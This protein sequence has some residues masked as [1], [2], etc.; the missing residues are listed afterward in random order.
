MSGCPSPFRV[1]LPLVLL[2]T[3]LLPACRVDLP[4]A[5]G[6]APAPT[7]SG[8]GGAPTPAARPMPGVEPGDYATDP[9][10]PGFV[11][12]WPERVE[13]AFERFEVVTGLDF[14]SSTR[15]RI[16]LRPFGDEG[17]T[18]ELRGEIIQ[19][20]RRTVLHVNVEPLLG[21]VQDADRVLLRALG[22]AA[23]QDAERRH[24]PV[25]AWV[26][27]LA[28]TAAAGDL[29]ARLD[30]LLRRRMRGEEDVLRVDA[31]DEG[32]AE[33]T[34]LAALALLAERG[35]PGAVRR[36]LVFMADGD[37]A[38]DVLGRLVREPDGVWDRPARLALRTRI[39]Q[40]DL[41]PWRLLER[42]RDAARETGRAGFES[43]VP[44][45]VP[46]EIADE[47]HVLRA[48]LAAA[49]GDFATAR[50]ELAALSP[51]A[52]GRL[53]DPAGVL[54]L[55]VRIESRAG[56]DAGLVRRL[57]LQL[58][59]DH[60]RS[61]A[62]QA[63]REANP[64]LGIQEDPQRWLAA[65]RARIER[66]GTLDLDLG[67]LER[68]GRMLV[69]D[70]RAG[71]AARFL[72]SLGPRAEAPELTAVR[73]LVEDAQADPSPAG[74][75]RASE[76]VAA[77]RA[78]SPTA[79]AEVR[80][81]GNAAREALLAEL[82]AA[83][84]ERRS[85]AVQLLAETVTEAQAVA[86]VRTGWDED[87]RRIRSDLEALV[88]G[89][90]Y[91]PLERLLATPEL[92]AAVASELA[93]AWD[94]LTF[95]VSRRWLAAHPD[96]LR[97]VRDPT[98]AV[99]R[100]AFVDLM[101]GDEGE[102]TPALVAHGLRDPAALMRTEAVRAAGLAGFPALARRALADRAPV[103][104]QEAVAVLA[105]LEGSAALAVLIDR[106]ATDPAREVRTA[107]A[108]GLL[109][110]APADARA[111]DA[112]L[113]TQVEEES[114]L[115]DAIST[116]LAEQTPAPVVAGIVR[117][118]RRALARAAPHHGYL[119]RTA[120]LYQRLTGQDL[121][122]YPQ[123]RTEELRAMLLRMEAWLGERAAPADT[124][125]RRPAGRGR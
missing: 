79:A 66:D 30:R 48:D 6:G 120:L 90:G 94:V 102:I 58:E 22:E 29:D 81:S 104:R 101:T 125:P 99:R 116:R 112:L 80:D 69:L 38:D 40:R 108:A 43:V 4:V 107:A 89:L 111:I 114:R 62:R 15:P 17:R 45:P 103:V 78:G 41:E 55:R 39:A 87:P 115:R 10:W 50:S 67:T 60:P 122:F 105:R 61:E 97:A 2:G 82:G 118:W 49:E 32:T 23:F 85:A 1:L 71:A 27:T 7:G 37:P 76:R 70:H 47:L 56:G 46:V 9:R 68:Y 16:V 106:L 33:A 54:A 11:R 42:A 109:Q 36:A 26:E 110:V 12:D 73:A 8:P 18:H 96:F 74:R 117:G 13:R 31:K 20:R 113:A 77:W 5:G 44:D 21:G 84:P 124:P 100:A 98:F 51:E 93:A 72:A 14:S 83:E 35:E 65:T 52:P 121:R 95:G 92:S 63:L 119:F 34:G 88:G 64:L 75:A 24:G 91:E 53:E 86:A 3:L 28:G 25:P 19:G 57:A 123:A 59:R